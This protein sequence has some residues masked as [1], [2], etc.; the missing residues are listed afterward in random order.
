MALRNNIALEGM[1]HLKA[2][3]SD[4]WWETGWTVQE[5][6]R[7][8]SRMTLLVPYAPNLENQKLCPRQFPQKREEV[9]GFLHGDLRIDCICMYSHRSGLRSSVEKWTTMI[10]AMFLGWTDSTE[11]IVSLTSVIGGL[12]I[13]TEIAA[14]FLA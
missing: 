5:N 1:K 6:Y 10:W 3:T 7:A 13:P 4:L 11:C 8:L 12:V 14:R 2:I 9:T